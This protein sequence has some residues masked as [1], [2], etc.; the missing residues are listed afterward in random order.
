MIEV[1]NCDVHALFGERDLQMALAVYPAGLFDEVDST[2]A[3]ASA[4]EMLWPLKDE[5]PTKM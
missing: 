1:R 4:Q 2:I 5:R 3:S